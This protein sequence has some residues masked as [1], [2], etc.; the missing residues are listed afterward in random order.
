MAVNILLTWWNC[1]QTWGLRVKGLHHS[2]YEK[3]KSYASNYGVAREIK[4]NHFFHW[5]NSFE[6]S[7]VT[8]Q[9]RQG[10]IAWL[11]GFE[12]SPEEITVSW[13]PL[14]TALIVLIIAGCG[15]G[16]K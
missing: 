2:I 11:W 9:I 15:G 5:C 6:L 12:G 10:L 16:E 13:K 1:N 4:R 3:S 14:L 8:P 7:S